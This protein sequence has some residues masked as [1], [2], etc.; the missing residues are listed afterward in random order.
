MAITKVP[1]TF[2]GIRSRIQHAG[3][4][5]EAHIILILAPRNPLPGFHAGIE[6]IPLEHW[7][8]GLV[9]LPE[10]PP[11]QLTVTQQEIGFAAFP[12]LPPG[13]YDVHRVIADPPRQAGETNIQVYRRAFRIGS[14]DWDDDVYLVP[15]PT[16]SESMPGTTVAQWSEGT[17][18]Y[19]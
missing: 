4:R 6:G 17:G 15:S 8:W 13:E 14:V 9:S 2:W 1:G 19:F 16:A 3:P 5:R 12:N 10:T 11:N 7:F 18:A